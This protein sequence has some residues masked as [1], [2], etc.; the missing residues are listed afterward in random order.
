MTLDEMN[1][2]IQGI[3]DNIFN[4][5]TQAEPG[6]KPVM[7]A[8]TTMLS[9]MKP[10]L[11]IS[12]K[13]FRNPWT[14]GNDSGSK[15]AAINTARLVDAA[16]KMSSIYTDSGNLISQVY[17]QILDGVSMPAQPPNPAIERQLAGADEVLYRTVS[18]I[19]PDTGESTSKRIETQLYRDYLDN[20]AA[21]HAAKI[22]YTGAFLEAQKTTTGKNTWPLIASTLQLPVKTA[23]DR[24][25]SAGADRVEQAFA[26]INTSTQNALQK[27]WDQAKKLYEGYGVILEDAGTGMSTPIVRSS[28]LPSDWHSS[29]RTTGWTTFDSASSNVATSNSSDY[30]SGGGAAGFSL[31]FF[32][33]GGGGGHSKST[34]HASSETKNMRISFKYSLVTIRR[35]WMTFNLFATKSWNV[36]NLFRKGDVSKGNKSEQNGAAMP[37]LPTS[38]VVVKDVIISANWAAS[39]WNLI[40]SATSGGGGFA[41]GPFVIGGGYS[42]SSS[43]ETFTSAMADG[44][45]TVPGVQIIGFISQVVPFSPPA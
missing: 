5:V 32:T 44:K 15:D 25:R 1:R 20:Q 38:F 14:P 33:I 12:S 45:I 39:D 16:P 10:G 7:Q 35:P 13:D 17:K 24:W 37:L 11:A 6:G 19:D 18:V 2:L 34:Q 27:A 23:F 43:K 28:L 40:K 21:Y 29:S 31:G 42:H 4:S 22:A 26:I 9:L 36:G 3:F 8:S 30:K 41:I